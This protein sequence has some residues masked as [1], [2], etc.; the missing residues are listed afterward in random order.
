MSGNGLQLGRAGL[1]ATPC[2]CGSSAVVAMVG[3]GLCLE[4]V[5]PPGSKIS[6]LEI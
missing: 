4:A 2:Q 3:S 5:L 6:S 1:G